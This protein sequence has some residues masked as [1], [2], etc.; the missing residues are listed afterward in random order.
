MALAALSPWPTTPAATV[1]ALACLRDALGDGLTDDRLARIGAAAAALVEAFAPS[2]PDVIR[3]EAVIRCAGWLAEQPAAAVRSEAQGDV[4]TSY[5]V[6]HTGALRH[7]GA[8]ALLSSWK[9]RRG[10]AI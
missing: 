3:S 5:A 9:Q 7:S 8:M 2:A 1:S 6:T 4:S 10:G